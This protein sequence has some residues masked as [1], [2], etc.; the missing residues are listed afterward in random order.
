[1]NG[2][3]LFVAA[4]ELESGDRVTLALGGVDGLAG[5]VARCE[6]RSVTIEFAL[7]LP[8]YILDQLTG[9]REERWERD[10]CTSGAF[11]SMRSTPFAL[12]T[13]LQRSVDTVKW[14]AAKSGALV[15]NRRTAERKPVDLRAVCRTLDRQSEEVMISDLT[16]DGCCI[17]TQNVCLSLGQELVIKPKSMEALTA[18]VCWLAGKRAGIAFKHPLYGPVA[19]HLQAVHGP[20]RKPTAGTEPRR[21]LIV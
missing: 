6:G 18:T 4:A 1:M 7:P 9:D 12:K 17:W 19:E 3:S 2:C 10:F 5:I 13:V 8:Q 16:A 14:V 15:A 20:S 11:T 21:R